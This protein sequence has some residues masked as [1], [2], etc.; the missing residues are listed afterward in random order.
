[1]DSIGGLRVRGGRSSNPGESDNPP[2]PLAEGKFRNPS[3]I[4]DRHLKLGICRTDLVTCE[5]MEGHSPT[6]S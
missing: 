5:A 1:M 3:L 4:G 6:D 2:W